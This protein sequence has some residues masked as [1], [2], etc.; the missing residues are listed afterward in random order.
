MLGLCSVFAR[1]LAGRLCDFTFVNRRYVYHGSVFVTG[2]S[3]LLCPLAK[4][5]P[6]LLLY[7]VTFGLFDGAQSAVAN[8]LLL[9]SVREEQRARAFGMW[10]FCMSLSIAS[11][12]PLAGKR[13]NVFLT[14]EQGAFTSNQRLNE[15]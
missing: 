3:T 2:V 13:A 8:V 11:G 10:L 7:F 9:T 14:G 4:T 6:S 15:R 5:F 12:P 1:L